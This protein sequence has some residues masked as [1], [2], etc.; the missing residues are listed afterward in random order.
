MDDQKKTSKQNMSATEVYTT[1]GL[2]LAFIQAMD[3]AHANKLVDDE[4]MEMTHDRLQQIA[5]SVGNN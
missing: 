2:P 3:A 1:D 4:N 5:R